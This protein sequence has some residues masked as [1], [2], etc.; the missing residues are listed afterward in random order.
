MVGFWGQIGFEPLRATRSERLTADLQWTGREALEEHADEDVQVGIATHAGG[1][2]A[3]ANR[4][5]TVVWLWGSIWG[6]EGPDGYTT[7]D[8][9]AAAYC[10]SLYEERGLGFV[11][12]LNGTFAGVVYDREDRSVSLFTDRLGSRPIYYS[13]SDDGVVFSTNVQSL[14]THPAVETGFDVEYLAEYFTL[15]RTFGVKTPLSGVERLQPGSVTTVSLRT[16]SMETDRYWHPHRDPVDESPAYFS[17]RLAETLVRAVEERTDPETEYGLL[18]S[19]GSDSRLT[20]AALRA[21]GRD[22]RCYHLADWVNPEA[23]IAKRVAE[24]ADAPI[25]LLKRGHDYQAGALEKTPQV[26][27]FV[28]YFN[29]I[30]ASGFEETL[31]EDVEYLFTGHYGDMLFKGNHVPTPTVD[32][33]ALGSFSLPV[34]R[35]IRSVGAFVDGRISEPPSYISG[36][37]SRS[38]R[39]I[40]AA[41]VSDE[42]DRFVDHGAEYGS[43]REAT[44][45]S[46]CPLTNG[47]SQFFYYGTLQTMPTGTPFL[48]NRL[49]DLFLSTPVSTLLRGDL[50]NRAVEHLDPELAAI[51]HGSTNVALS[52]P[53]AL[54]EV[55]RVATAFKRRHLSAPLEEPHW[56]AGPWTNHGELIRTQNFVRETIDEHEELIRSLPFLSWAG[57]NECYRDHLAGADNLAALYTLVTF[58]RM[59]VTRRLARDNRTAAPTP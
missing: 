25:T 22:V 11:S 17:R 12:G 57:V 7:V 49:V 9:P 37:L 50:I 42:G 45:C 56:T 19:G 15:Q 20:L 41:N 21:A 5:D 34:E 4:G 2:A 51:P 46:R 30:H 55:G 16:A 53:S 36:A 6:F 43:V 8:Q 14:P 35:D 32:L 28:G 29:Q 33:G 26:G 52:A 31:R 59:P 44:I 40:Y 47:T 38:M 24:A 10:A 13:R 54:Q 18:L 27:N 3:M 39:E 1:P 58:L 23:R 48:D